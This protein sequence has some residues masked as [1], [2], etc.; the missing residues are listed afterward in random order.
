MSLDAA[1]SK[2]LHYKISHVSS[3]ACWLELILL[4]AGIKDKIIGILSKSKE[5]IP[6]FLVLSILYWAHTDR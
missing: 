2:T 1:F 5:S 4:L 6:T 3:V